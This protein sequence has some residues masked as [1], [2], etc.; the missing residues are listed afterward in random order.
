VTNDQGAKYRDL[1]L[2]APA[3]YSVQKN[4]CTVCVNDKRLFVSHV[5]MYN[6]NDNNNNNNTLFI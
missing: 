5:C 3:K 4:A 1:S 2:S 6:N